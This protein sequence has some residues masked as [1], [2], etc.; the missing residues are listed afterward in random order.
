MGNPSNNLLAITEKGNQMDYS[1]IRGFNYQPSYGTSGLELWLNF[2][3]PLIELEL[4]RGKRH[5]PWMNA[6]RLWLSWDAYRRSEK[7]FKANFETALTIADGYG[8]KVVPVLFNRWHTNSIDYGGIYI[9]HFLSGSRNNVP[10]LFDSYVEAIVGK[11]ADDR[12]IFA[13]DLCNEPLFYESEEIPSF[14][15]D[16]EIAWLERIYEA[17]K[18]VNAVAPVTVAPM[19][20]KEKLTHLS[21]IITFHSYYSGGAKETFE[22]RLDDIVALAVRENKALI[23]TETCW[24]SYDNEKRAEFVRYNLGELNKRKIG[25]LCYLLHTSGIADAHA[26]EEGA[27]SKAGNLAFIMA[28]G[29]LRPCHQVINE[30]V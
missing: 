17:C 27:F 29:R 10:E 15:V 28:D 26:E 23:A 30:M 2:Q 3:A 11:H 5:F 4:G 6:I 1:L 18:R 9:D 7:Q 22:R 14:V 12:R 21:D 24:G 20:E 16:A 8:L 13:W 25:W 19:R